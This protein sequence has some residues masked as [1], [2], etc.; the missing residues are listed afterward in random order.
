MPE[1]IRLTSPASPDKRESATVEPSSPSKIRIGRITG[2]H[3]LKGGLRLRPDDPASDTLDHVKQVFIE[4]G[5]ET[6]KCALT[7]VT[8]LTPTTLRIALTGIN[9]ADAAD[10]LRGA[11]LMVALADLPPLGA[12]RFYYFQ[13]DGCEVYFADGRL[14]GTIVETFSNGAHDVWVVRD[15]ERE[16]LVPVVDAI[17]RAMDLEARKVTIEPL[18]GL[19]D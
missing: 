4:A 19:L 15:G 7:A 2:A 12:N 14:L 8:R 18:P 6:R 3:G 11:T 16:V 10:A 5:G 13:A 9:D 1:H 17:V